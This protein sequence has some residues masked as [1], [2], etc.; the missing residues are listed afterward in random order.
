MLPFDFHRAESV[1]L[2]FSGYQIAK[3]KSHS[4]HTNTTELLVAK[5]SNCFSHT[6]LNIDRLD[7]KFLVQRSLWWPNGTIQLWWTSAINSCYTIRS[8]FVLFW[9]YFSSELVLLL[10]F[11]FSFACCCFY[12]FSVMSLIFQ[13]MFWLSVHRSL[14]LYFLSIT[15]FTFHR[16]LSSSTRIANFFFS[17]ELFH[18]RFLS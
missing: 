7:G 3:R 17:R 16:F 4:K 9:C 6:K 2:H 13:T 12:L 1:P 8:C 10:L 14:I 5:F 18:K 15:F 11:F